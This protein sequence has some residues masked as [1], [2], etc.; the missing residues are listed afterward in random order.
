MLL[1][2]GF[3]WR[4]ACIT[5]GQRVCAYCSI[6]DWISACEQDRLLLC[7]CL[8]AQC[9]YLEDS[10]TSVLVMQLARQSEYTTAS[11]SSNSTKG[12]VPISRSGLLSNPRACWYVELPQFNANVSAHGRYIHVYG[13]GFNQREAS[14]SFK[15]SITAGSIGGWVQ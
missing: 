9:V 7:L 2:C 8:V 13:C 6:N 11:S 3:Y 1:T 10:N 12:S 14:I 4:A 5:A 15:L